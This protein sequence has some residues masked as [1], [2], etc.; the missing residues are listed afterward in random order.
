MTGNRIGDYGFLADGRTGALVGRDGAVDWWCPSRFD[1]PSVFARM[2]DEGGGHWTI[3]PAADFEVEREYLDET[4]V[5]RTVFT[6]GEGTVAV[7]DALALEPGARGHQIGRRSPAMLLRTVEGLSGSVPILMSFA[8]RFEYGRVTAYL[9]VEEREVTAT[10]GATTLTMT[11]S[12]P[13]DRDHID[14]SARFTVAAGQRESFAVTYSPTYGDG[15]RRLPAGDVPETLADTV[16]GWRSWMHHHNYQGRYRDQVRRSS[17]VL[18][19]LTFGPSGAVVAAGTTSLP[20]EIGGDRNYDYRYAWLRDFALTMRALWVAACP[21]E[22]NRLFDWVAKSVG[23]VTTEPVPIMYGPEGERDLT[24]HALDTLGGYAGSRPVL[25]GNDAWRQ[26]Q[27]DVLGEVLDAAWLLRDYLDPMRESVCHL[28][29]SLADQAA[30]SWHLPDAGMWEARDAQRHYLSSKVCCW[31]ALDRAVLFGERI[32]DAA[33]VER[34]ARARDEVRATVLAQGWNADVGA[35]TGAFGS[36]RLDASVLTLPIWGFLPATDSRM[37]ATIDRIERELTVD[38][39]VRRWDGDPAAF[40]LCSFWLVN[41]LAQ[42]GEHDRASLMFESLTARA[43]DLG[44]F[45]EQFDPRTGEQLGN[46]PQAFSHMALINTA[47]QLTESA[48]VRV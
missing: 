1:G 3:R 30:A 38:G 20:E 10:A 9:T 8:P 13:V 11:A 2:L 47:W 16:T 28:L 42:A 24:E 26:R 39:L 23:R 31:V 37:R 14:A 43:N 12:V 35:Y 33:D 46:F 29:R 17:L 15:A 4:L 44:L 48:R 22:A 32:G 21:D 19:G 7:T 27:S 34:W 5:L 40:F 18:Q 25:V 36:D 41:C 6:T 45:A